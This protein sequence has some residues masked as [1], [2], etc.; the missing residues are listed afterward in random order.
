MGVLQASPYIV[1]VNG[2]HVRTCARTTG[3]LRPTARLR[4]REF[5]SNS[6]E[7]A[8]FKN[9]LVLQLV[10]PGAGYVPNTAR[11]RPSGETGT[12]PATGPRQAC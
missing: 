2:N 11:K 8:V 9:Q 7:L 6:A 10:V 1:D 3:L 4:M 5:C 12:T